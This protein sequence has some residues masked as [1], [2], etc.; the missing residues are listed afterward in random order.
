METFNLPQACE[1]L[2]SADEI[3]WSLAPIKHLEDRDL[4]GMTESEIWDYVRS[5]QSELRIVRQFVRILLAEIQSLATR[6]K[7]ANAFIR[8]KLNVS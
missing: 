5:L 2:L 8:E 6:L 7:R 4:L 1:R 3:P